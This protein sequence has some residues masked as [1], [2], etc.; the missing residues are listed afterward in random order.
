[1]ETKNR[2]EAGSGVSAAQSAIGRRFF[3]SEVLGWEEAGRERAEPA[4]ALRLRR[5]LAQRT[6]R[7]EASA[8][9]GAAGLGVRRVRPGS[10]ASQP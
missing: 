7:A 10:I 8:P 5:E 6:R 9:S 4:G 1:M 3:R 2:M